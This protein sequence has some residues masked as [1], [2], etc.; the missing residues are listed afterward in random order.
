M[1]TRPGRLIETIPVPIARPRQGTVSLTHE[2]ID[3]KELCMQLL[4]AAHKATLEQAA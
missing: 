3:I 1:A 2:F 4:I